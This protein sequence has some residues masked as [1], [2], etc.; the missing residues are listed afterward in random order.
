MHM[1]HRRNTVPDWE[2][3]YPIGKGGTQLWKT[4]SLE[5]ARRL[6]WHTVDWAP[7][8]VERAQPHPK[9]DKVLSE[10]CHCLS[11]SPSNPSDRRPLHEFGLKKEQPPNEHPRSG[12]FTLMATTKYD[13]GIG[14]PFDS[15]DMRFDPLPDFDLD[16][17]FSNFPILTLQAMPAFDHLAV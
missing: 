5:E 1:V 11:P 9:E 7:V 10:V 17:F 16:D 2:T 15:G 12:A 13:G 3:R 14:N 6:V 4:V 8:T